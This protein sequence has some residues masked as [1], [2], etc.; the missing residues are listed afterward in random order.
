MRKY[1]SSFLFIFSCFVFAVY[2]SLSIRGMT[3]NW[4]W[5]IAQ[6]VSVLLF[7]GAGV[8]FGRWLRLQEFHLV[9]D[10][11]DFYIRNQTF[12]FH[13]FGRIMG[14]SIL[15]IPCYVFFLHFLLA[16]M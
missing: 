4:Y 15:G 16:R 6:W 10:T 7:L 9:G 12:D 3:E 14:I 8:E 2:N 13:N 5:H 1:V 11:Y